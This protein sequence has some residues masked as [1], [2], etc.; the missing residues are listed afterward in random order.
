MNSAD[1]MKYQYIVDLNL[2]AAQMMKFFHLDIKKL[3]KDN[4]LLVSLGQE[5]MSEETSE[6]VGFVKTMKIVI[7]RST[8]GI[9]GMIKNVRGEIMDKMEAQ[10]VEVRGEIN[11]VKTLVETQSVEIKDVRGE[12]KD[13]RGEI[14]DVKTLMETQ[15]VEIKDVRGE[16]KDVRSEIKDVRGEINDVKIQNA[17]IKTQNTEMTE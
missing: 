9:R 11:D 12:I 3:V 7:K 8:D 2:E 13:V 4:K 6:W 1:I 14:N 5:L 17:E 10:N 16:I 15:S